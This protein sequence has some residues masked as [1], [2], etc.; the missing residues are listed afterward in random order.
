MG[1]AETA[2]DGAVAVAAAMQA[3]SVLLR[4]Q[5]EAPQD[6]GQGESAGRP[7]WP[8]VVMVAMAQASRSRA[9]PATATPEATPQATNDRAARL[10]AFD[11]AALHRAGP[12]DSGAQGAGGGDDAEDS[13]Q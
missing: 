6:Q 11:P 10:A 13:E 1:A 12:M 5:A 8:A 7:R 9:R 3:A 2:T 4:G